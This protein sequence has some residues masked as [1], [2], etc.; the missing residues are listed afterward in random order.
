MALPSGIEP[1]SM[2]PKKLKPF[3]ASSTFRIIFY[4]EILY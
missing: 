1:E 3:V 4:H 2:V